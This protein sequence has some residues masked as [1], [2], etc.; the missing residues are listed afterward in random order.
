MDKEADNIRC[1]GSAAHTHHFQH[2]EQA[3]QCTAL[4]ETL[5]VRVGQDNDSHT[6]GLEVRRPWTFEVRFDLYHTCGD[7]FV[8]DSREML[9]E[10]W[11]V[12]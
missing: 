6:L 10:L 3:R 8:G 5:L 11:H 4:N 2:R 12:L 7:K 1:K 9:M